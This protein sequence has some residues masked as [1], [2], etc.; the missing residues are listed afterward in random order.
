MRDVA[1]MD[2]FENI[3]FCHSLYASDRSI[4]SQIFIHHY[5]TIRPLYYSIYRKVSSGIFC[6]SE[7]F[8]R[9]AHRGMWWSG[10]EV[11]GEELHN[12]LGGAASCPLTL[13]FTQPAREPLS[14]QTVH[15][16]HSY[17]VMQR[18]YRLLS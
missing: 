15:T 5:D 7:Q 8:S 12:R 3:Y 6:D 10:R 1:G 11:G 17:A 2:R 16:A 14:L 13:T 4:S 9:E 18:I